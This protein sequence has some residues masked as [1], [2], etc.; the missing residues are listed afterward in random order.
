[1][2]TLVHLSDIH[3]GRVD[4]AIITPL[5]Q[6]I[7][8]LKP[9]VVA[10]SGDLTQR[11]RVR[12]FKAARAFLDALP[13]P[14]IV[15]PGN[16]DIPLHNILFRF[17][18]PLDKYRRYI[19]DEMRPVYADEEIAVLGVNT[20]RSLTIKGGRINRTQVA[21]LREK[22]CSFGPAVTKIVVTHH[23]FD[24]PEGY[25]DSD[26]VGRAKMAIGELGGCGADLFLAGHL[27]VSHTGH[28]ATR[29]KLGG[30]SSLVVQAGTAAS[31]RGRGEA[32]SFNVIR[33]ARPNIVIE[34]FEW[35]PK[36]GVFAVSG[37]ERF[38]LGKEGWTRISDEQ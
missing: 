6:T 25:D 4:H 35:Q 19:M 27:H 14:Q 20:A 21:W 36:L 5:I 37:S 16:H 23:P 28:T 24:V 9:D 32:N 1:M 17:V 13:Q 2:R 18:R 8:E 3:F 26:L 34:L 15:V 29:Y 38:R 10:V 7:N 33:V 22:L 11:A 30:R 12:E 31:T